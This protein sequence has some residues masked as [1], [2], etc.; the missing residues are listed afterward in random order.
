MRT[1]LFRDLALQIPIKRYIHHV[2]IYP[3]G[4]STWGLPADGSC[5]WAGNAVVGMAMGTWSY[6]WLAGEF[7]R[8]PQ[9][10]GGGGAGEGGK[11]QTKSG[12]LEEMAGYAHES[13]PH[14][15]LS[16]YMPSI[17]LTGNRPV[18]GLPFHC[19]WLNPT[20]WPIHLICPAHSI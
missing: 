7:W 10:K 2:L 4:L 11:G 17:L 20:S 8:Q 15:R 16:S 19:L 6:A 18:E 3:P 12:V 9:V 1:S 5:A 14:P 13:K